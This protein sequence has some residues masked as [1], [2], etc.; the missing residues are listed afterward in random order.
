VGARAAKIHDALFGQAAERRILVGEGDGQNAGGGGSVEAGAFVQNRAA[1]GER[2]IG[3]GRAQNGGVRALALAAID[4]GGDLDAATAHVRRLIVERGGEDFVFAGAAGADHG[5]GFQGLAAQGRIHERLLERHDAGGIAEQ[6]QRDAAWNRAQPVEHRAQPG[7]DG[8]AAVLVEGARRVAR[9]DA[10]VEIGGHAGRGK[11]GVGEMAP[12][13][14]CAGR[15]L[16]KARLLRPRR[17]TTRLDGESLAGSKARVYE[18]RSSK[19]NPKRTASRITTVSP[20]RRP[21]G[22]CC[23][24]GGR[25]LARQILGHVRANVADLEQGQGG[26]G[27][28][29]AAQDAPRLLDVRG[30]DGGVL[31]NA[32]DEAGMGQDQSAF[33]L[34]GI[35]AQESRARSARPRL[36]H[37]ALGQLAARREFADGE[38][39]L[40]GASEQE[41]H[42]HRFA[43]VDDGAMEEGVQD[44]AGAAGAF[45]AAQGGHALLDRG[46]GHD[47]QVGGQAGPRFGTDPR[48]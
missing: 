38:A 32:R 35:L 45:V 20:A 36:V 42:G 8:R 43:G 37:R 22:G 16:R 15:K 31:A 3:Q 10:P 19:I 48:P 34:A 9:G 23:G 47:L 1:H 30:G 11:A 18:V 29:A 7:G 27:E 4:G 14:G 2:G 46:R 44:G 39:F 28:N 26:S 5:Q 33:A 12:K 13:R 21:R 25:F 17:T 6:N 41:A 24:E 40:F